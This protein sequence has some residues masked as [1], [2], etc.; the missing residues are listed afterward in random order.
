M[1]Q[2]YEIE[3]STENPPPVNT[4]ETL[5]YNVDEEVYLVAFS[6]QP[7][8]PGNRE[9]VVAHPLYALYG[10][11]VEPS[12]VYAGAK[13]FK[14]KIAAHH[15]VNWVYDPSLAVKKYDGFVAQSED[16]KVWHNQFPMAEYG[17]TSTEADYQFRMMTLAEGDKFRVRTVDVTHCCDGLD[18]MLIAP[19]TD[20][21]IKAIIAERLR[22]I[23]E[24]FEQTFPGKRLVRNETKIEG[25]LFVE[26]TVEPVTLEV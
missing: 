5:R 24:G 20:G 4:S 10:A 6:Y 21:E 22:S 1:E 17:Q 15:K 18:F 9:L 25:M 2:N 8:Y 16:G 19:E 23:I 3:L 7:V 12:M 13:F 11:S 26:Y 14:V